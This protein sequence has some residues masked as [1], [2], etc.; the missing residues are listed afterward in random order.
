VKSATESTRLDGEQSKNGEDVGDTELI[1][2][3]VLH[4]NKWRI[5]SCAAT[6]PAFRCQSNLSSC[7]LLAVRF[8]P[9]HSP[10]PGQIFVRAP[11]LNS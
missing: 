5:P 9:I 4:G 6:P 2:G 1:L 10:N 11:R 7:S 3:T 8:V